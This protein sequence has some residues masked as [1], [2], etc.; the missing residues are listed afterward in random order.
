MTFLLPTIYSTGILLFALLLIVLLVRHQQRTSNQAQRDNQRL[1]A[2]NDLLN[3][4]LLQLKRQAEDLASAITK[5]AQHT[6][7]LE[8]KNAL[9]RE[10]PHVIQA[11]KA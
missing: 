8:K 6:K 5:Q 2:Q 11:E 1:K 4:R 9:L 3:A 7:Q 10:Q